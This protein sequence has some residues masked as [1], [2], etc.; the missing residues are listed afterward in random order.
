MTAPHPSAYEP[1][2]SPPNP[3]TAITSPAPKPHSAAHEAGTID[4]DTLATVSVVVLNYNGLRH[5]ESCFSSLLRLD[6]PREKLELLFVDNASRDESVQFMRSEYPEVRIVETGGNLG[7]AEGN[8]YGAREAKGEW[9]AFLNNDTRVEP[10][11][12]REL[13]RAALAGAD[14]G[15][16]CTA[17]LMLD[18]SGKKVDFGGGALNFHGFGFQ[19][20]YGLPVEG[21]E[22]EPRELL[23]ACGGSML[24][25]RDV[26]L[27][28]GGFDRD[29]FAFFEDVDLG[30]RLWVLGYRVE[31]V[32]AAITY[33]RHHG[34]FAD[35]PGHRNYLLYE[36]NALY[37]IYKNY[38]QDT[39]DRALPAALLLL[40]QR[41]ARFMEMSG[42]DFNEYDMAMGPG[43]DE[44]TDSVHRN[45]VAA[46]LAVE[47]FTA[48]LDKMNE[49]RAW[50]QER[51]KR[52]DRELFRR[53]ERPGHANPWNHPSDAPY[54]V[55]QHAVV[56]EFG[57]ADL[58]ADVPRIVLIISPD[59]LPVGEIPATGSGIRA[60]ALGQGLESR[61]HKVRYTMPAPALAGREHLVP[62]EYVEGAW[63]TQNLQTIIDATQPDVIVSC[64]W[65]NLN[66]VDRVNVPTAI[67]LTGPHVLERAYQGHGSSR[68]NAREKVGA[69]RKG[70][71][72]TCIGER[73]RHYFYGWLLQAGVEA[74]VLERNLAVIPY[75]VDPAMPKHIW[76]EDWLG[77]ANAQS[78]S[79]EPQFVFGGIFLPWQ[80]PAPA[81]LGVA[82]VLEEAG[83]G[84]LH[85]IGGKH[86]FYPIETEGF[87]SMI[88]LLSEMPRVK[89][90]G[91]MAHDE[92]VEVYR[93]AHV[94]VDVF[95]P[96]PERVLA[97]PS[98]TVHYLWCGLPVIHAAF[99]EVADHIRE[100]DAGWIVPHDDPEALAA[101]VR[102]ILNNPS[103]ATIKGQNAQRLARERFLWDHTIE[104]LDRFVRRP[105]MR[106]AR[107]DR[108]L[109]IEETDALNGAQPKS[110]ATAMSNGHY[111][112]RS[113]S[114]VPLT[115][116]LQ[117][118][119]AKRRRR[120]SQ[121]ATRTNALLRSIVPLG[122]K[123]RKI[124][125]HDGRAR[126]RLAELTQGHSH[127]FRFRAPGDGLQSVTV[128]VATFGRRN[129]A[130]LTLALRDH[131]ASRR[132]IAELELSTHNLR[133][134]EAVTLS[135][136]RLSGTEG[137]WFYLV[138]E[139]PDG[140]PG[141]AVS[142]WATDRIEGLAGQRYEDG[143]PA[144]GAL[145][146][147]LEMDGV[148][149]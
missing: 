108:N 74:E 46:L 49:K 53:F 146:I 148:R 112:G 78:N 93:R 130:R 30:W 2:G 123:S 79:T 83:R 131:P 136:P 21:R 47:E 140:A 67:D 3:A 24:I 85:V 35:T 16:I 141:D 134:G 128:R 15:L 66:W 138:A 25:R 4:D 63:T 116:E 65:P 5:L 54:V 111:S 84:S 39:L 92:L 145:L 139:S 124:R 64:G 147:E 129:T 14:S 120:S 97:F 96:N 29:Y 101:V 89:R 137:R 31:L 109:R 22:I 68:A 86:P 100:Y 43:P 135:F 17:S 126:F 114:V 127:G 76:P 62:R 60:W 1:P 12:L 105:S 99:S 33:H 72:Y 58:W 38:E 118:L 6:Y 71:F 104:E 119:Q 143:L 144:A 110:S 149:V 51:R 34:S 94:A 28:V 27:D 32:P 107:G 122:D 55:A 142:R 13:V 7:F 80:N 98:R 73:Q 91:L 57:L 8:N 37:S 11:W 50:I 36:R 10:D 42:V 41:A 121:I 45:A 26:F 40:G 132:N 87:A 90:S 23:F 70:D 61:G 82:H 77:N 125:Y 102:Q 95:Q 48:S 56:N 18:W 81:L 113:R 52:S 117:Q 115:P 75:S 9:V 59:V 106:P 20:G 69:L 103:L 44:Q 19:P 133:E 88:D